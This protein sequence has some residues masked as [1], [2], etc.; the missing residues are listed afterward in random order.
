[1]RIYAA[2]FAM[3]S[4]SNLV[5]DLQA[6]L[7]SIRPAQATSTAIY[8]HTSESG[9]SHRPLAMPSVAVGAE[10]T[11]P[12]TTPPP[13]CD[14]VDFPAVPYWS[15]E[16]WSKHT[17]SEED[18]GRD[19]GKFGFLTDEAGFPVSKDRVSAMMATARSLFVELYRARC[20]PETWRVVSES[21]A[22]YFNNKISAKFP[23]FLLC[24]DQWKCLS[25]ATIQYPTWKRD[26]RGKGKITRIVTV[27]HSS[28]I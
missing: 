26:H 5:N 21:G 15:K 11:L 14:R 4:C 7:A 3:V 13:P 2:Y 8:A 10:N 27:S 19:P 16:A 22:E 20:D 12:Q 17:R 23:E 25:F 9:P 18:R 28:C 24:D 1:M 6:I